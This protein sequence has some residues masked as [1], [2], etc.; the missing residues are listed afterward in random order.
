MLIIL[1]HLF[2][3]GQFQSIKSK[4]K[5]YITDI[6]TET[7]LKKM[8]DN[9]RKKAQDEYLFL[10]ICMIYSYLKCKEYQSG[11]NLCQK[12]LNE[13]ERLSEKS[14]VVVSDL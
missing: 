2:N 9:D 11:R 14:K 10:N 1:R 13:I 12:T 4:V 6:P 7:T 8:T 5:Q 3:C